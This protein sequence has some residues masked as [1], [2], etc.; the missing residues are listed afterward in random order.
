[1]PLGTHM[2]ANLYM[3]VYNVLYPIYNA[4]NRLV[5]DTFGLADV[6]GINLY[7]PLT[8]RQIMAK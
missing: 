5:Y 6:N 4:C 2:S 3:Q 7:T 1:M 8:Y